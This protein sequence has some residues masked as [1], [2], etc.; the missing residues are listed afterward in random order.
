LLYNIQSYVLDISDFNNVIKVDA[1]YSLSTKN[2]LAGQHTLTLL[3]DMHY[4]HSGI[5]HNNGSWA[6]LEFEMAIIDGSTT[7]ALS[8]IKYSKKF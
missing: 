6:P 7:S 3:T 5:L 2:R 1:K 8:S 4:L